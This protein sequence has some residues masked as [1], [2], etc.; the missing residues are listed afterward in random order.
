[1]QHKAKAL[2]IAALVVIS[3]ITAVPGIANAAPTSALA[4]PGITGPANGAQIAY[5]SQPFVFN[6]NPVAGATGYNFQVANN[7]GFSPL[8]IS[9]RVTSDGWASKTPLAA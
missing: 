9:Y 4:V 2:L 8:L 7:A 5:E 1:M 3:L 6:W